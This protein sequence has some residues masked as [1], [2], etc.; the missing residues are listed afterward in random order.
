MRPSWRVISESPNGDIT[1][2]GSHHETGDFAVMTINRH[3]GS[4]TAFSPGRGTVPIVEGQLM[5]TPAL[6]PGVQPVPGAGGV[7]A[8]RPP[9][10]P[11]LLSAVPEPLPLP[12]PAARLSLP[13]GSTALPQLAAGPRTEDFLDFAPFM[14]EQFGADASAGLTWSVTPDGTVFA[15][16]PL[17]SIPVYSPDAIFPPGQFYAGRLGVPM[18]G[19]PLQPSF[20]PFDVFPGVQP[21]TRTLPQVRNTR[22]G[23]KARGSAAERLLAEQSGGEREVTSLLPQGATRRTD[24]VTPELGGTVNRE[25]KNYLRYIGGRGGVPR[26]VDLTPFLRT[27]INR[28]AM[29]M[30][31]YPNHQSIWVFTDAPPSEALAAAL[32]EA[33]IPYSVMSDRL[34]FR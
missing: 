19:G 13:H 26:E 15:T 33:G 7:P 4:G 21:T 28:D 1:A 5:P 11:S 14:A 2:I 31:Y 29:I 17:P 22:G 23:N 34:P 32:A 18:I 9:V 16:P 30:Y 24:L 3:T 12:A 20:T 6:G 10:E 25:V 27:E 8:L